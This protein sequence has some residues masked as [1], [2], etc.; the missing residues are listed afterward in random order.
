MKND[1]QIIIGFLQFSRPGKWKS[2]IYTHGLDFTFPIVHDGLGD[3]EI[4]NR[5]VVCRLGETKKSREYWQC[6]IHFGLG[7]NG[8]IRVASKPSRI[9]CQT[10]SSTPSKFVTRRSSHRRELLR[11]YRQEGRIPAT[12]APSCIHVLRVQVQ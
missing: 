1:S 10:F 2:P 5:G 7:T 11:F 8:T 6:E 12:R 3:P 9:L 4:P